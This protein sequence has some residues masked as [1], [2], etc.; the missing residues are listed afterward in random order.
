[1]HGS[2]THLHGHAIDLDIQAVLEVVARKRDNSQAASRRRAPDRD[3][4]AS[5]LH[6]DMRYAHMSSGRRHSETIQ[7]KCGAGVDFF[8]L[9]SI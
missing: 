1:M 6:Q 9:I 7:E 5:C 8:Y 4:Q 2:S 3:G